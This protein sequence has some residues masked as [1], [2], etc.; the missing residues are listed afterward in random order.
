M[1][2]LLERVS[3][4]HEYAADEHGHRQSCTSSHFSSVQQHASITDGVR[5]TAAIRVYFTC[6][7]EDDLYREG[8]AVRIHEVVQQRAR[9]ERGDLEQPLSDRHLAR[10]ESR[11]SEPRLTAAGAGAVVGRRVIAVPGHE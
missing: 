2:Y 3:L 8:H 6:G 7:T 4:A 9:R 5:E 10:F 11:E 1:H